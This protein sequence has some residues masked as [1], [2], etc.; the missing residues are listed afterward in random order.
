MMR[1]ASMSESGATL[2]PARR[3]N[4]G[5][6][7]AG[8]GSVDVVLGRREIG[9]RDSVAI[10]RGPGR[11]V[12]EHEELELSE[13]E[14]QRRRLP[15]RQWNHLILEHSE[16]LD[17]VIGRAGD[18]Q[19]EA[20]DLHRGRRG[21]AVLRRAP[22]TPGAISTVARIVAETSLDWHTLSAQDSC[23]GGHTM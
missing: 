1:R 15:A 14:H 21:I 16:L 12:G 13:S 8:G 3:R 2:L 6:T 20:R 5:P 18:P 7:S 10:E 4:F 11:L 23:L 9:S 22:P 19:R 17:A